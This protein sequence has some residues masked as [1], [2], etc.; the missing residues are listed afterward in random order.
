MLEKQNDFISSYRHCLR[1]EAQTVGGLLNSAMSLKQSGWQRTSVS[2]GTINPASVTSPI[3]SAYW[4]PSCLLLSSCVD[5]SEWR[6]SRFYLV[7]GTII[8]SQV[9]ENIL[10][11]VMFIKRCSFAYRM[12]W[13]DILFSDIKMCYL[14]CMFLSL[15]IF[16][17]FSEF[18]LV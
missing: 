7:N 14:K 17:Y 13:A 8:P 4:C 10:E 3:N 1:S 11:N 2:T 15:H 6:C 18:W 9:L 5:S 12:C 16:W